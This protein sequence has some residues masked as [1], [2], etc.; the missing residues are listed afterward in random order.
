MAKPFVFWVPS[1]KYVSDYSTI[2][3][4]IILESSV[5]VWTVQMSENRLSQREYCFALYLKFGRLAGRARLEGLTLISMD[6]EK[7]A[8]TQDV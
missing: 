6:S 4:K 5:E 7:S 1:K 8:C 3:S 2:F